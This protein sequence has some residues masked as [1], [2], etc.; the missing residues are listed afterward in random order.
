MR[1]SNL[2]IVCYGKRISSQRW[3]VYAS[4]F[5]FGMAPI[6]LSGF[7]RLTF[8]IVRISQSFPMS[9]VFL[10]KFFA[11]LPFPFVQT[12]GYIFGV[13][14]L[15]H[16]FDIWLLMPKAARSWPSAAIPRPVRTLAFARTDAAAE[17]SGVFVGGWFASSRAAFLSGD[18]NWFAFEA[19]REFFPDQKENNSFCTSAAEALVAIA[20]TFWGVEILQS[21]SLVTV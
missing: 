15:A 9:K 20:I 16:V 17:Q 11:L 13:S 14:H 12:K 4:I 21:D 10:H 7:R 2:S 8:R 3:C 19:S 6:S 5:F 18:L 1:I